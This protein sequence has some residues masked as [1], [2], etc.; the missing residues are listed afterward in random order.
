MSASWRHN[1]YS[2]RLCGEIPKAEPSLIITGFEPV[3]FGTRAWRST[4]VTLSSKNIDSIGIVSTYFQVKRTD[5]ALTY[6][7]S[8]DF[9]NID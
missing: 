9:H 2:S 8:I 6:S 5:D 4:A 7:L 3:T 1:H